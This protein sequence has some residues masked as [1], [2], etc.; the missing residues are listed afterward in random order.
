MSL[1]SKNELLPSKKRL[2]KTTKRNKITVIST[3]NKKY[4]KDDWNVL[5]K[6]LTVPTDFLK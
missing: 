4:F 2:K 6:F 1:N 5:K 3:I